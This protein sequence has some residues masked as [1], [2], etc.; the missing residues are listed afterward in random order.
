MTWAASSS[1][2][3]GSSKPNSA[4]QSS[5][6]P[7]RPVA[8]HLEALGA[9]D[10][11]LRV[12]DG[13]QPEL[14]LRAGARR[15]RSRCR[16]GR[17]RPRARRGDRRGPV[18]PSSETVE[19]DDGLLDPLLEQPDQEALLAT[20]VVVE[21]ARGAIGGRRPPPRRRWRGTP[22]GRTGPLPTPAG[23]A[24]VSA[25][26]SSCVLPMRAT[27]IGSPMYVD[28]PMY[29]VGHSPWLRLSSRDHRPSAGLG[30]RRTARRSRLES[31]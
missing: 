3:A 19:V 17:P 6:P 25:R 2:G 24:R 5:R 29:A 21:G 31:V 23:R 22:C 14:E 12:A 7:A 26:R 16:G 4:D 8:H 13:V 20:E 18:S 11:H 28:H 1:A 9:D 27:Y 30:S 10:A 15:R